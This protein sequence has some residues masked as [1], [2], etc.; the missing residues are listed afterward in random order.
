VARRETRGQHR[1]RHPPAA[2]RRPA[3]TPAPPASTSP[4]PRAA[5]DQL[6]GR[7]LEVLAGQPA[8]LIL[9]PGRRVGIDPPVAQQHLGDPVAGDHQI[10][11]ARVMKARQ[12]PGGLNPRRRNLDRRELTR[13]QQPRERLRVLAIVLD[14]KRRFMSQLIPAV[15]R[16]LSPRR[17]SESRDRVGDISIVRT[18]GATA[19]AGP[20]RAYV[21]VVLRRQ[22]RNYA[23][24]ASALLSASCA[25]PTARRDTPGVAGLVRKRPRG[26]SRQRSP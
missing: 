14:P 22:C 5:I 3:T 16:L 21:D 11:P 13:E 7:L 15:P 2:C 24:V 8:T 1:Q 17:G 18:L 12:L 23:R 10:P 20:G 6:A 26:P 9:P 25:L 4:A 19:G